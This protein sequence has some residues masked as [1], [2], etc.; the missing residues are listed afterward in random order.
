[1]TMIKTEWVEP[2]NAL[3]HSDVYATISKLEKLEGEFFEILTVGEFFKPN[4]IE[5]GVRREGLDRVYRPIEPLSIDVKWGLP[6][7]STSGV[8]EAVILYD[9]SLCFVLGILGTHRESSLRDYYY[10]LCSVPLVIAPKKKGLPPAFLFRVGNGDR[11]KD[12]YILIEPQGF[13][14]ELRLKQI[15]HEQLGFEYLA[16]D[17][18]LYDITGLDFDYR[19]IPGV[20]K[21][22]RMDAVNIVENIAKDYRNGTL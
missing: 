9:H 17:T 16:D 12:K 11:F 2:T 7:P 6:G 5:F 13:E 15:F 8:L 22:E 14:D 21:P 19:D 1:M 3:F 20:C 10:G 4:G 18:Y